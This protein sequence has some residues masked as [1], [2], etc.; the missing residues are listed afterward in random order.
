MRD[1]AETSAAQD[2]AETI[3]PIQAVKT[4]PSLAL[5]QL[6]RYHTRALAYRRL[7]F[8][9]AGVMGIPAVLSL[10]GLFYAVIFLND[11][12][13]AEKQLNFMMV[14]FVFL[15][16]SGAGVGVA[17]YAG[18]TRTY[19][20]RA[21]EDDIDTQEDLIQRGVLGPIPDTASRDAWDVAQAKLEEYW[22]RN[23][24]QVTIIFYIALAVIV[25]G[26]GILAW[27]LGS[28]F[29]NP[30]K[31]DI[32]FASVA[33]GVI[34]EFIGAT[35][36][37]VFRSVAQQARAYVGT[38]SRINS[39]GMAVGLLNEITDNQLKDSVRSKIAETLIDRTDRENG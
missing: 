17:V 13:D 21:L 25:A 37:V 6:R 1:T 32:A 35:V 9:L 11:I 34:T 10:G 3:P 20:I 39:V 14:S 36:M 5:R 27:G 22:D 23:L 7:L 31:R 18:L 30:A 8:W 15:A 16:M 28:G 38:L 2:T 26:F 29:Q 33:A 24:S 4:G 19:R 12:N